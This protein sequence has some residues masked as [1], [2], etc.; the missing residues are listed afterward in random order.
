MCHSV[1]HYTKE[2]VHYFFLEPCAGLG[3]SWARPGRFVFILCT[4]YILG[5]GIIWYM[6]GICLVYVVDKRIFPWCF[7]RSHCV[8]HTK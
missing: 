4:L 5:L 6:F 2:Y 3:R 1:L 8:Q 7:L